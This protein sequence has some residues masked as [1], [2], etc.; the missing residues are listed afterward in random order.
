MLEGALGGLDANAGGH[1]GQHTA[2]GE[3]VLARGHKRCVRSRGGGRGGQGE[4]GGRTTDKTRCEEFYGG[5]AE[6]LG[7]QRGG[8]RGAAGRG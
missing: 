4:A 6:A 2:V 7:M 5:G 1:E 8:D 3:V